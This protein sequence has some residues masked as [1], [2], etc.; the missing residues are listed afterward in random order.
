MSLQWQIWSHRWQKLRGTCSSLHLHQTGPQE[1]R[2]VLQ[3]SLPKNT[4]TISKQ[5]IVVFFF[6]HIWKCIKTSM[7]STL[8]TGMLDREMYSGLLLMRM[9]KLALKLGSSKHGNAIRALV[10]SKWVEARILKKRC[11]Q[12]LNG[13]WNLFV[14]AGCM[15]KLAVWL[16]RLTWSLRCSFCMCSYRSHRSLLQVQPQTQYT[17]STSAHCW[18]LWERKYQSVHGKDYEELEEP[19]TGEDGNSF[20]PL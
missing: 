12:I 16:S 8:T 15:A 14:C 20:D 3:L 10:G 18:A 7:Y 9:E 1:G 13:S 11:Q 5:F 4:Q 19:R 17:E 2:R 6:P